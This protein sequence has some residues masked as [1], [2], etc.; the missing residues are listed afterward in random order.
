MPK[1]HGLGNTRLY[2]IWKSMKTRCYN[3]KCRNFRWYGA[4]GIN[5]CDDWKTFPHFYEWAK[6]NG[7]SDNLTL[8][9]IDSSLGYTPENCRWISLSE[10]QQNRSDN[11]QITIGGVTKCLC[12]WARFYGISYA[13]ARSHHESGKSWEDA[14]CVGG[15][16]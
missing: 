7:Y 15:E 1:H 4:K 3:E 13:T 10:Q 16:K 8:D 2:S 6:S 9:R 14:F 5:V 12:E 11:V